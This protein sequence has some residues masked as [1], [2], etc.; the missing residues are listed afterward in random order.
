[1]ETRR[2]GRYVINSLFGFI[3]LPL[4]RFPHKVNH[5]FLV[6]SLI[7]SKNQ[8]RNMK[9]GKQSGE[10][11]IFRRVEWKQK[12]GK[13][14]YL[15]PQNPRNLMQI[16]LIHVLSKSI[17]YSIN[18]VFFWWIWNQESR[19]R[20][21]NNKG[22]FVAHTLSVWLIL[23]GSYSP[24][25]WETAT[26]SENFVMREKCEVIWHCHTLENPKVLLFHEYSV[27]SHKNFLSLLGSTRSNIPTWLKQSSYQQWSGIKR[28]LCRSHILNNFWLCV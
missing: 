19:K 1:M 6:S 3:D 17:Y 14:I 27:H 24:A 5:P 10:E 15:Y 12:T 18:G 11:I 16:P 20:T 13:E 4:E 21:M 22:W 7:K 26:P 28:S 2:K 9:E 8:S 25:E 23:L